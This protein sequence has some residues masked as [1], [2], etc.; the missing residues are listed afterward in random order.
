MKKKSRIILVSVL[1]AL[2]GVS[3]AVFFTRHKP[4]PDPKAQSPQEMAKYIASDDFSSLSGKE[5]TQYLRESRDLMRGKN[6][7]DGLSDEEKEKFRENMHSGNDPMKKRMQEYFK[8]PP[9]QRQEYLKKMMEEMDARRKSGQN[10]PPDAPPGEGR[11]N[12]GTGGQQ[13]GQGGAPRNPPS[14]DR[15]RNRLEKESPV[16]RAQRTQFMRDM[17]QARQA[18]K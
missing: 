11:G 4:A 13:A 8:L 7:M 3:G 14:A 15:I 10:R 17:M 18:G 6:A 16:E 9:D 5:R 2:V 1:V 12:S